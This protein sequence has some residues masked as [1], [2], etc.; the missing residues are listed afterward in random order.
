M[1]KKGYD[2]SWHSHLPGSLAFQCLW[3][4]SSATTE[5][6]VESKMMHWN[7]GSN[8]VGKPIFYDIWYRNTSSTGQVDQR[9]ILQIRTPSQNELYACQ[10]QLAMPGQNLEDGPVNHQNAG[11]SLDQMNAFWWNSGPESEVCPGF[12][13]SGIATSWEIRDR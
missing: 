9:C 11:P 4:G 1:A 6:W 13:G 8:R 2:L 5:G 7:F 3:H 10:V 12:S